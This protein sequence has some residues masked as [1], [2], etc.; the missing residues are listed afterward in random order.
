MNH[1]QR[2]ASSLIAAAL[3]GAALISSAPTALA[4]EGPSVRSLT[5]GSEG[6]SLTITFDVPVSA[7][8][9]AGLRAELGSQANSEGTA[10]TRGIDKGPIYPVVNCSEGNRSFTDRNGTFDVRYNCGY[11]VVNWGYKVSGA[12]VSIAASTMQETGV[13]WYKG[14]TFLGQNAPHNVPVS[15]SLHGTQGGMNSGDLLHWSD[16]MTFKVNAGGVPGSAH[17]TVGGSFVV[18]R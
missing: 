15:Y 9:A 14:S 12:L 18:L 6:T 10:S 8:K 17:L 16:T 7:A 11:N 3:A 2:I 1:R 5:V 4:A 13:R